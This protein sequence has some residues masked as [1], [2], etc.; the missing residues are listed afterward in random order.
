M[1]LTAYQEDVYAGKICPYC[2]S[3]TKVVDEEY[4]YGKKYKGRSMICCV[5]FP[6][7]DSYVGTHE[8]DGSSL[9]RLANNELRQ[10]KKRAHEW[11]DKIWLDK[12]M[13]RTTAYEWLADEIG[14]PDAYTHI[15]MFNIETC[16]KVIQVCIKF[17]DG[18]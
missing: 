13:D 12:H 14:T 5:R 10:Y 11:F 2:K 6:E 17:F 16:R 18:K 4:I 3:K 1:K 15:G 7:C 9:G 8:D